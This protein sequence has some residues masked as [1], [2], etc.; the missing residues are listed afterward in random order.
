M[1]PGSCSLSEREKKNDY[2]FYFFGKIDFKYS[3]FITVQP[4]QNGLN[5]KEGVVGHCERTV[6]VL[7]VSKNWKI[8]RGEKEGALAITGTST[9]GK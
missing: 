1:A 4:P 6:A 3:L 5:E 8:K 2:H 9:L 7:W